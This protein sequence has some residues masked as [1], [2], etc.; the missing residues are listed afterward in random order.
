MLPLVCHKTMAMVQNEI[1]RFK[2]A[3]RFFNAYV[4][5]FAGFIMLL[6]VSMG[7]LKAE[8]K[9]SEGGYTLRVQA[10]MYLFGRESI[11]NGSEKAG[12][13]DDVDG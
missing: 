7:L 10:N 5:L 2:G 8:R 9:G 12:R 1:K 13:F 6:Q 3:L 11:C 4:F